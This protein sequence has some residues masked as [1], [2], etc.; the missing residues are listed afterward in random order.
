VTSVALSGLS[1]QGVIIMVDDIMP[2]G[3]NARSRV[4]VAAATVQIRDLSVRARAVVDY[5]T[6]IAP[7]KREIALAHALEVGIAELKR[8]RGAAK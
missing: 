3:I 8:R 4:S 6:S 5:L 7:D 2:V 1:Q